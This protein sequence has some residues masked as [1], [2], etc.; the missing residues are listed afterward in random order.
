MESVDFVS[1]IETDPATLN[2]YKYLKNE[3]GTL[4]VECYNVHS[5]ERTL[6]HIYVLIY[7]VLA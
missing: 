6:R 2:N 5:V 4:N 3:P 1:T 7:M